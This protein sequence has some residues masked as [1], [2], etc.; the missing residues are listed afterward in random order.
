MSGLEGSWPKCVQIS[1]QIAC[2]G[3]GRSLWG[4]GHSPSG[5][6]DLPNI[7]SK[8]KRLMGLQGIDEDEL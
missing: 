5:R 8:G 6:R 3:E 7:N 4:V 2:K 1:D